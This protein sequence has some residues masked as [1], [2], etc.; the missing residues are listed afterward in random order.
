MFIPSP[1]PANVSL[2][3]AARNMATQARAKARYSC[4]R[5]SAPQ[6]MPRRSDIRS[7]SPSNRNTPGL[8]AVGAGA[9]ALASGFGYMQV[10]GREHMLACFAASVPFIVGS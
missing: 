6:L 2:A 3:V 5:A 8:L 1:A 10:H 7:L 9:A 4:V